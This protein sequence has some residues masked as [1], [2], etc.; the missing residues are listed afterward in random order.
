MEKTNEKK[1]KEYGDKGIRIL[2]FVF[3]LMNI[4]IMI[5]WIILERKYYIGKIIMFSL[6]DITAIITMYYAIIYK[7]SIDTDKAVSEYLKYLEKRKDEEQD[8]RE[9]DVL[10]LMF[11]NNKEISEYFEISKKQE[12]TSYIISVGCA[13]IGVAMLIVSIGAVFLNKRIETT[14]IT[15]IS[16]AM[17]ELV[18]GIVLW[19]HNKSAMQLN[20]YYNSLHENE[21]FLSAIKMVDRIEDKNKKEQMYEEIIKAQIRVREENKENEK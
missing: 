14:I 11:K 17:T 15:A 2:M 7:K 9:K 8:K 12:K 10:E 19:I 6:I 20:F 1:N 13:I 4:G 16:G 18:S 5:F 21:K 3:A